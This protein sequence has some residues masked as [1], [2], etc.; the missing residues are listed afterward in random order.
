MF[1]HTNECF[2]DGAIPAEVVFDMVY[3]PMETLL[4][5][6]AREGQYDLIIM[7]L[8]EE[9]PL[10]AAATWPDWMAVVL[11]HAHCRVFVTAHPL[12]PSEMAEVG[13]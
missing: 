7:G 2:F 3:N 8:Q 6:R 5:Q 9:H 10:A 4:V 12:I 11:A 13:S 1:P